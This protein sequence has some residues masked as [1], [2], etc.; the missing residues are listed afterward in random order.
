MNKNIILL[1]LLICTTNVFSQNVSFTAS[2]KNVVSSG[3]QFQLTY[4]I[5][6]Q[7]SSLRTPDLSSFSVLSGPSQ[8]SSSSVQIINGQVSQSSSYTYT[9]ILQA[10]KV[11]KFTIVP[12]EINVNGKT[13]K[14]NYLTIEVVKGQTNNRGNSQGGE[15]GNVSN[16]DLFVRV[17]VNRTSVYQG[18]ALLAV[19][20]VYTRANIVGFE[21]MKLPSYN[22]FWSENLETPQQ[23]SLKQENV[24]GTIYNVGV[25]KKTLLYPQR[26]GNIKIE[27]FELECVIQQKVSRNSQSIFDAFFGSY[28]NVKKKVV[29]QPITINVKELP[30]NKPTDFSGAVGNIKM[31]VKVDK[32]KVKTNDAINFKIVLSGSGNLKLIESPKINFPSDFETYDPK[33]T[34]NISNT[35]A[36]SSGTKTFEYLVIPRHSGSFRIPPVTLSYFD[37][38]IKRYKVLTSNEFNIDVEKGNEA[39][40]NI[41]VSGF[42]KEDVKLIGSDI[43][44]IKTNKPTLKA[45]D[46]F[47]FGSAGF[48]LSYFGSLAFFIALFIIRRKQIKQ[49]ANK[50]LV[51]NRRANK[52]A[53]KRMKKAALYLKQN[54]EN[55]FYDEVLKAIWGYLSDKL[56]IQI[57]ELSKDAVLDIINNFEIDNETSAKLI[58]LLDTCEFAK[59]SSQH[60][61]SQMDVV[62]KEAENIISIFEQKVR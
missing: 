26:S 3:E 11:G 46:E 14:S 30:A 50:M 38:D 41:V 20:K 21:N 31:N 59:Y 17:N 1:L 13:Y 62:Y 37:T 45:K 25:I 7:G 28:Q 4:S 52:T 54:N 48:Y 43:R 29:S 23:I 9:Y 6:A 57:A 39:E 61:S 60:E 47:L 22:G 2:A 5:N 42:N 34:E 56:Q 27:P 55:L 58:Q 53:K 16:Q 51:R 49:N 12:A 33:V 19:I 24:N 8:S 32:D 44:Y 40:S 18:E 15:S 10:N 35:E 36:G